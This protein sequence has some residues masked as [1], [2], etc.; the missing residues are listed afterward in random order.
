MDIYMLVLRWLHILGGVF[1]VGGTFLI[2]GFLE[3]TIRAT[4][5]SGATVMQHLVGKTKYVTVVSIAAIVNVVAGALMYWR[6][7][8]E[9][10]SSWLK[11][12][13]GI[14]ITVGAIAALI[15]AVVGFGVLGRVSR[16]MAAIGREIQSQG[17]PPT[18]DQGEELGKLQER[19]RVGGQ[20]NA[21]FLAI[22]ISGMALAQYLWF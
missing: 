2:A 4:G 19:M 13:Y 9:L 20:L 12:G 15:S 17:G 7:S 6:V 8:S 18:P 22:A 10:S 16:R 11:S 3:P 14:G 1:W 5:E 21:I